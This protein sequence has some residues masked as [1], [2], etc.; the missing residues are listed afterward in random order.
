MADLN[1]ITLPM[2]RAVK[3]CQA[4]T[5]G[6]KYL[7]L[8]LVPFYRQG[9]WQTAAEHG[10]AI[11]LSE[12]AVDEYRRFLL[13]VGLARQGVLARDGR[14]GRP[15]PTWYAA[16]PGGIALGGRKSTDDEAIRVALEL[17][18]WI[19]DRRHDFRADTPIPVG[20]KIQPGP[21]TEPHDDRDY[22]ADPTG[23][24][25]RG[26]GGGGDG[27]SF[28]SQARRASHSQSSVDGDSPDGEGGRREGTR[29]G[30][31]ESPRA[32]GGAGFDRIRGVPSDL[33]AQL[34]GLMRRVT[35]GSR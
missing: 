24:A 33:Q 10:L 12:K 14:R 2:I 5:L 23:G 19:E 7:W 30:S 3:R 17:D 35:G 34:D 28:P 1:P 11:G 13:R 6:Q 9:C 8:D 15:R 16:F 22:S 27:L 25:S 21:E 31:R 20:P 32:E 18:R 26:K 29:W 4:L